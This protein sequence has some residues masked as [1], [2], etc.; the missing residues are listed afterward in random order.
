MASNWIK[1]IGLALLGIIC[2]VGGL[3]VYAKFLDK[4]KTVVNNEYGKI[5]NKGTNNDVSTSN[6]VI[7]SY[8][9]HYTKLYESIVASWIS[10]RRRAEW[11]TNY[12]YSIAVH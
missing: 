1:Q 2:F 12:F 6:S 7:T 10:S 8:S 3:F 9:I 11:R 5:K 4:P